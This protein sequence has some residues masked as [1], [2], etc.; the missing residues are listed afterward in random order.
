MT[1]IQQIHA[2]EVLD[3]RGLPTVEVEV[4]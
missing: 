1:Q 4:L 3:S 2:R